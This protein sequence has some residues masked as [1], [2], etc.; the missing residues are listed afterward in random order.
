LENGDRLTFTTKYG[1]RTYKVFSKIRIDEYDN[2]P[3]FW[4]AENMLTLIT[5]VADIPELRYCVQ[6]IEIK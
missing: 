3:L 5:C 4:S 1:T 6:A 2:L